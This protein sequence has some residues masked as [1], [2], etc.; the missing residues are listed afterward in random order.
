MTSV[1]ESNA[2]E[3]TKDYAGGGR[4]QVRFAKEEEVVVFHDGPT[5]DEMTDMYDLRSEQQVWKETCEQVRNEPLPG[6]VGLQQSVETLYRKKGFTTTQQQQSTHR[7]ASLISASTGKDKDGQMATRIPR[8]FEWAVRTICESDLRGL[9]QVYNGPTIDAHRQ[10]VLQAV[11]AASNN[12]KVDCGN[13]HD[14][15]QHSAYVALLIGQGDYRQVAEWSPR[16]KHCAI[17][18]PAA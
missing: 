15:T 1:N 8:H 12:E 18:N 4:R 11:L 13:I 5:P 16:Q 17:R 6:A 7:R 10:E 9:E 3:T 2:T 14:L